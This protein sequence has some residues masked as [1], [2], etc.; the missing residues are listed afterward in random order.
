MAPKRD[1]FSFN[2]PRWLVKLCLALYKIENSYLRKLIRMILIRRWGAEM[3]SLVLRKIFKKY[4]QIE[5]G[6]YSYGLF[7]MDLSPVVGLPRGTI[8]GRYTSVGGGLVV[9]NGSHPIKRMSSH[10]F[11]F[12]SDFGFVST[13]LNK[14]RSTLVIGND[15]YIG[16]NVTIMPSVTEIGDGAVIAAGSVV[17]K[18]V[19]PYAVVGG[20]PAKIIKYRFTPEVIEKIQGSK[21][22]EKNIEELRA[23]EQEFYVFLKDLE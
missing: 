22:W 7:S 4:H 23:N 16:A 17:L 21:W 5:I 2:E 19:T 8:V 1:S 20:N 18:N 12:N 9:L 13:R 10:P 11:F 14:R 6:L 15:V 3:Y